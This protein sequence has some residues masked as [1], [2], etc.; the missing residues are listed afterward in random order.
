MRMANKIGIITAAG[1]GMGKAAALRFAKEGAA[2]GVVDIDK[3]AV[4]A[5]VA[6]IKKGGGKAVGIVAD[7]TKDEESRR[8]VR[9]TA[10]SFGGL[11]FVWNHVG[12]PGPASFERKLGRKSQRIR[13]PNWNHQSFHL[14]ETVIPQ[15][16]HV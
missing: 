10:K 16:Q 11:D 8:I 1:S 14:M 4:D 3:A 15:A 6:E 9:E 7:L 13:Q 2:V 12:H 5:V